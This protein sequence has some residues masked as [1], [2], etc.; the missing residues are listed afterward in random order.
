[1]GFCGFLLPG[2]F[3][4]CFLIVSSFCCDDPNWSCQGWDHLGLMVEDFVGF[5]CHE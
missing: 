3:S 1:M 2:G 5:N 4:F